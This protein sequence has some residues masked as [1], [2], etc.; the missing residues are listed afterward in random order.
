MTQAALQISEEK[1]F[2]EQGEWTYEDYLNLPD[3]GNR[4]EIIEGRLYMTNAP[5]IDHQFAVVKIVSQMEQFVSQNKLGYVLTA[6]FEVHLSEKS[7]PVQPDVLFVRAENWPGP[8]AK[9]FE[10][11]P[12]LVVEVLSP[13]SRRTDQMIK[14]MAYEKAKVREYWIADPK[15]RLVQVFSLKDEKYEL[16]GEFVGEEVI[17]S[18]V[19]QDIG[20]MADSIFSK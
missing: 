2:P 6:P 7:R 17:T 14:F 1:D 4:Y 12:D 19:L 18:Q 5:N 15:A 16:N 8:G 10:G 20:I 13:S 11:A 3:D 9:Y